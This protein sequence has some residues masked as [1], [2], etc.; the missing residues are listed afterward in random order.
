MRMLAQVRKELRQLTR[1]RLAVA[2]ALLLPLIQL[3]LMGQ[4]LAFIV[5]DLPV[6]V[7]D[8]DDSPASRELID[9]FRASRTFR[10]VPWPPDR[11]PEHAFSSNFARG[12]LIVPRD[13]S[14]SSRCLQVTRGRPRLPRVS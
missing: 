1:D 4:S 14:S 13:C 6:V 3:T 5:K 12:A 10:V 7:Q 11:Q 2:L 9:T 8:L